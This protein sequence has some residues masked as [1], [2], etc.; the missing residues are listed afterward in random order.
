MGK[1]ASSN[2]GLQKEL[3]VQL[4]AAEPE[5]NK[6]AYLWFDVSKITLTKT[7]KVLL[8]INGYTNKTDVPFRLHVYGIPTTKW[9]QQDLAWSNAPLLDDKEALLKEVGQKAFIAGEIAFT[10]QP[11]DHFLDVTEAMKKHAGKGIS[12]VLV[13]ETRQLGD[14][15]DKGK[16]VIISSSESNEKPMLLYWHTK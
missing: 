5:K 1:T 12:F 10:S 3:T 9:N 7:K 15:E 14:D 11:H 16:K 6:V 4:D 13:R 8:K 2:N